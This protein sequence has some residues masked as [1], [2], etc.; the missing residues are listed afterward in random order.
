[1]HPIAIRPAPAPSV[2]PD[3]REVFERIERLQRRIAVLAAA[4]ERPEKRRVAQ[5]PSAVRL[6]LYTMNTAEGGCATWL[7]EPPA[8][9]T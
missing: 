9:T 1:M 6:H 4:A 8:P 7:S 2:P 5:P 3:P